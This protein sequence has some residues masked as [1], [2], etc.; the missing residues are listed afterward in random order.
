M[1]K[2]RHRRQKLP[3]EPVELEI[4]SVSH[5]GRGVA[6]REGKVAFVDGALMGERVN[7]QFVRKRSKFDEFK[8]VEVLTESDERVQPPCIF[9]GQCGGCS[10]QHWSTD[11]QILFKQSVLLEQLAHA[12]GASSETFEVL[13]PLLGPTL[14]YRRKARLGVR[15]VEKKG[16]VL[17][18]FREKYSSFITEM[19]NCSILITEVARLIAPLRGLIGSL[20]GCRNIPQIEVAAGDKPGAGVDSGLNQVALVFRHLEEL[21]PADQTKLIEFSK[22]HEVH[23]YLQPGG[24]DSVHK[25][26]PGEGDE[27]LQYALPSEGLQLY[28]HPMD[29]TQINAEINRAIVSQ[30]LDKLALQPEDTVLDL[31]CGLGNFTLAIAKR[32]KSVVGV[33]GSEEM[34]KRGYENAQANGVNN[35]EFYAA[36]LAESMANKAWSTAKFS[37]VLLDPPRSGAAEIIEEVAALRAEKIVYVSCNPS[38]LARDTASLLSLG[39]RLNSAGVMDMFPHTTHV[40]SM[41]EFELVG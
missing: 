14:N 10:L 17:V 19:D 24:N 30:A 1:S 27:R 35:S 15:L 33:E 41:A 34:V 12:T 22:L 5:E 16:G 37:K 25:V 40:E 31:F 39:Y 38:T 2:R 32:C 13:E 26:F 20:D 7:A 23:L 29:F 28:F 4:G 18:G 6:H 8:T 9:T 3:Q 11:K 21:S 36:N